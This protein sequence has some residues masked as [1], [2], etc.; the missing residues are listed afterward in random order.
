MANIFI[1]PDSP[2]AIHS[3]KPHQHESFGK[4]NT[5]HSPLTNKNSRIVV[6]LFLRVGAENG[7]VGHE[8]R[9]S[10]FGTILEVGRLLPAPSCQ[11]LQQLPSVGSLTPLPSLLTQFK[12]KT[13]EYPSIRQCQS[14]NPSQSLV[15]SS[16]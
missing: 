10:F 16:N 13:P 9:N 12:A 5:H 11:Q 6:H 3:R 4:L 14:V 2:D 8:W 1:L 7:G 15:V